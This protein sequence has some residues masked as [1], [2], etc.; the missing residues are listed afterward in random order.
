MVLQ[1]LLLF[2]YILLQK[3]KKNQ[4]YSYNISNV[5]RSSV[6]I[7]INN[8]NVN[9][10]LCETMNLGLIPRSSLYFLHIFFLKI[11]IILIVFSSSIPY[12][13]FNDKDEICTHST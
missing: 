3:K 13:F 8:Y 2:S 10:V 4:P 9:V 11:F 5:G 7:I 1:K 6:V 12:G